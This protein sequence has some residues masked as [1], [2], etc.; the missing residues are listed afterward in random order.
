[1]IHIDWDE[2]VS[3]SQSTTKQIEPEARN[4]QENNW[5]TVEQIYGQQVVC[6]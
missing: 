6:S 3:I 5:L 4:L 2:I 1:L